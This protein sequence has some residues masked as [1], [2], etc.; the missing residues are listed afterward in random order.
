MCDI[1]NCIPL[2]DS[3]SDNLKFFSYIKSVLN[4]NGIVRIFSE[5]SMWPYYNEIRP[6][7]KGAFYFAVKNNVPIIPFVILFKKTNKLKRIFHSQPELKIVIC[8]PQYAN[9]ELDEKSQIIDLKSRVEC[10]MKNAISENSNYAYY[11][12]LKNSTK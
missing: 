9:K 8:T 12:Y 7:K 5:S 4:E 11:V 3:Y 6:F 1:F 2:A 10:L